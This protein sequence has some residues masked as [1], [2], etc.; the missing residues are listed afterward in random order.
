MKLV[1][2]EGHQ[3][4]V[5]YQRPAIPLGQ[6]HGLNN[7]GKPERGPSLNLMVSKKGQKI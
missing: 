3:K 6:I 1:V 7:K 5:N 4:A 2:Q